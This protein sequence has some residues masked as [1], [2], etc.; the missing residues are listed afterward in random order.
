MDA[1]REKDL[2]E[3]RVFEAVKGRRR[4][5]SAGFI[6]EKAASKGMAGSS[7][8]AGTFA[9]ETYGRKRLEMTGNNGGPVVVVWGDDATSSED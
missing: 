2:A 5:A 7:V 4:R 6:I 9:P 8:E 3:Y 1:Q